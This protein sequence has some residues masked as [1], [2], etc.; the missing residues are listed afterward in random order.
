MMAAWKFAPALAAGNSSKYDSY[1]PRWEIGLCR[2]ILR[3]LQSL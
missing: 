1:T 2:L 3:H